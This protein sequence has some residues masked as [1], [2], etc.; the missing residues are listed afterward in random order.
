[1]RI[2][3]ALKIAKDRLSKVTDRASLES[4]ILLA[5][6]LKRDRVYLHLNYYENLTK[7]SE[8]KYFEFIDRREKFEPVEYITNSASFYSREFYV[9][10]RVLIPRP[11]T[12]LLIDR[13]LELKDIKSAVEIGVGSGVISIVLKLLNPDLDISGVDISQRAIEVASLNAK[14]Y[15]LDIEFRE[16]NLLDNFSKDVD[17]II[18][19]P[20][21]IKFDEKLEKNLDFE[22]SNALFGGIK[23]DEI[24]KKII[25]LAIERGVKYLICEMGYDQRESITTY[26]K[27]REIDNFSFY[28]DLA[29]LDRGFVVKF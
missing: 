20:P 1:M 23:G 19:N 8:V 28:R 22:P 18:S 3:E 5:K 13:I 27:E 10:E 25:D 6:A 26:L 12:E 17:A 24:L 7:D 9:D 2:D 4:E 11:E 29:N 15:S 14:K 21:Y 16:S